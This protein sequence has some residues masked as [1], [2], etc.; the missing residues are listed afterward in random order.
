MDHP[1]TRRHLLTICA[2]GLV[3]LTGCQSVIASEISIT[4][5]VLNSTEQKQDVYLELTQSDD[6]SYRIGQVLPIESGIAERVTFSVPSGMYHMMVNIDDIEPRPEKTV[7]WEV[8]ETDCSRVRY[9]TIS[10]A[11]TGLNLQPIEPICENSD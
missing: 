9:W 10:P 3:S 4:V 5:H 11:E 8:S 2:G 6:E 7:E 1:I